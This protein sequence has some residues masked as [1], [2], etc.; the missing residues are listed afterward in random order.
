MRTTTGMTLKPSK[1]QPSN[2]KVDLSEYE[3]TM[4]SAQ[5]AI[6]DEVPDG[7]YLAVVER[8]KVERTS[9]GFVLKWVFQIVGP[10]RAGHRLYRASA[11]TVE[12][13][14]RMQLL[15]RD[16]R[17]TDLGIKSLRELYRRTEE[18]SGLVFEISKKTNGDYERISIRRRVVPRAITSA[19]GLAHA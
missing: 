9:K 8:A 19:G 2:S 17:K 16:I 14:E 12:D 15:W 6:D 3:G 7:D 13:E 18:F 4:V 1:L 5:A 11:L 10:T